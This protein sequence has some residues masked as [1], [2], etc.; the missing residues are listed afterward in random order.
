MKSIINNEDI[1]LSIGMI[2]KNEEKVLGRCLE[3]LKP[4]R[5]KIS[6]EL[7]IADTGSTDNTMNIAQKYT[8]NVFSFEWTGDFSAARN[9]TIE[10]A[11]GKWYFFL[12]ADEYLDN[13]IEEIISFFSNYSNLNNYFI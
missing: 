7:I 9:S 6:C 8:E 1:V 11:K 4:L 3:S 5:D 13:D 12:D 2:V 10:K